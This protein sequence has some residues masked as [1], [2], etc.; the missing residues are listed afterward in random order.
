[1]SQKTFQPVF[2][3]FQTL[4]VFNS[5]KQF[6]LGNN[7][8]LVYSALAHADARKQQLKITDLA[9]RTGLSRNAIPRILR[10]L[11]N[12]EFIVDGRFPLDR[13][14]YFF[15]ADRKN[16][17]HWSQRIRFWKCL[18]RCEGS[19]LLV[20][21]QCV[22]SYVW[23]SQVTGFE[24]SNGWS[25]PYLS[26]ILKLNKKTVKAAI[27]RLQKMCLL[28]IKDNQ[29]LVPKSLSP[30]QEAWFL[31]KDLNAPVRE[32]VTL[33]EFE[34]DIRELGDGYAPGE[35]VGVSEPVSSRHTFDTIAVHKHLHQVLGERRCDI[36][37]RNRIVKAIR[38]DLEV[39]GTES[40]EWKSIVEKH[41]ENW[42][43]E[44]QASEVKSSEAVNAFVDL[45]DKVSLLD[46]HSSNLV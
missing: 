2:D 36:R 20:T 29:W 4:W 40:S 41:L 22:L 6:P 28:K 25:V 21:D 38:S 12:E 37:S 15:S 1:M 32:K 16:S 30:L 35:I 17:E 39:V 10:S 43:S 11:T 3:G 13:S 18:I 23:W 42:I 34:P 14:E 45:S 27:V 9:W 8:L 33:G 5:K 7:E 26:S 24:P 46:L 31:R 44:Q 19:K